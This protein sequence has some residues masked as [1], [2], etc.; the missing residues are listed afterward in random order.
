MINKQGQQGSNQ[1]LQ[2][3]VH[4]HAHTNIYTNIQTVN[5]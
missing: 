3:P 1:H 2:L 5:K 4:T